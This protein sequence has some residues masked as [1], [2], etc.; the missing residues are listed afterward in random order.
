MRDLTDEQLIARLRSEPEPA[1]RALYDRYAGMLLRFVYRFTGDRDRAED[2]LHDVFVELLAGRYSDESGSL[3]AW[4][5]TVAKN[6]SLN[7]T[8]SAETVVVDCLE[9]ASS[10]NLEESTSR[11]I[12]LDKIK[13]AEKQMPAELQETWRLRK[14]GMGYQQ[15]SERLSVPL[16]TVKSRIHRLVCFFQEA[17]EK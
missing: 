8:R 15:I 16:G 9:L 17:L 3:K 14:E 12:G 11:I 4:L 13:T 5:F 1:F 2:I 7:A 6:K 10:E